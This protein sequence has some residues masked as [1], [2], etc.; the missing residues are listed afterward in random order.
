[1]NYIKRILG[2]KELRRKII[3]VLALL[4][5]YRL[6]AH[7]P[8]PGPDP[9]AIKDFINNAFANN[10]VLS[11]IDIFSGG[12]MSRFSVVM[13]SLGPY[14]T[15]SIMIQLLTMVV[16]K[17]ENL[18]KE[19]EQGRRKLNQYSRMITVPLA[20]IEGYG[21][22]RFLQSVSSQSGQNVFSALSPLQWFVMLTSIA[23]GT[24]FL[25]W[26]GELISEKSI[27]NGI[28]IIIFAGIISALPA[29]IGQT[30]QKLF[31][32][33]FNTQELIKIAVFLV[34][35]LIVI[36]LIAFI[37]EAQRKIPISYAKKVR[38]AKLYGS[39]D[40]HLPVKL[41]MAGVIPIIFAAAFMNIP[42][43]I[44]ALGSAKTTWIATSAKWIQTTFSPNNWPYAVLLF[45][46]V[47][48]FT[49]FSTFLYFKPKDVSENIQ[50][51][52]GFIPGIRPGTQTEKYLSYLINRVTLWGAI[53]LSFIAILPYIVKP[54]TGD[55][56]LTVGGTGLLIVVGVA[57]EVKNQIEAQMI[58]RSYEEF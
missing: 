16:P 42:T 56:N 23:A 17:F 24:V 26:L 52:G 32:G 6:L 53:F 25:M 43:I 41:N 29:T 13:M 51:Q 22:I 44:G 8:V 50:K 9:A 54:L 18:S 14:V 47:F 10:N 33:G 12:G 30:I 27:G 45:V 28:S 37:T 3:F 35:A 48:V 19:G 38:G 2:N 21:M 58:I 20:Y 55:V 40:T 15:A 49:F 5:V 57:I 31:V 4:A 7:V 36:A 1:M 46:L 11:F 34:L 39:I